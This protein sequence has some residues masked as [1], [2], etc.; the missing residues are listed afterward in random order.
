M[1]LILGH[2]L[3]RVPK[4]LCGAE[5]RLC[6]ATPS[7]PDH[8]LRLFLDE[9]IDVALPEPQEAA[10]PDTAKAWCPSGAMVANPLRADVQPLR[11]LFNVEKALCEL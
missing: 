11:D 2:Q 1:R 7:P 8:N 10:Q 9:L 5:R 6:F 4:R 3:V